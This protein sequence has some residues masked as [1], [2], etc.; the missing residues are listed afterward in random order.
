[1]IVPGGFSF[2]LWSNQSTLPPPPGGT[3]MRVMCRKSMHVA[4]QMKALESRNQNVPNFQNE[5]TVG[6]TARQNGLR[7]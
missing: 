6:C 7:N 4:Y 2:S 1:M 5:T 3:P